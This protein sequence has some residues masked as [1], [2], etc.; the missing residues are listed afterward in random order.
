MAARQCGLTRTEPIRHFLPVSLMTLSP[1]IANRKVLL[2]DPDSFSRRLVTDTLGV[3]RLQIIE[4]T[5]FEPDPAMWEEQQ[6]GLVVINGTAHQSDVARMVHELRADRRTA[7]TPILLLTSRSEDADG[8]HD[9][10]IDHAIAEADRCV[11]KPFSPLELI[12]AVDQL[13]SSRRPVPAA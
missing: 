7:S 5:E 13:L 10:A 1:N 8:S 3:K 12:E 11:L 2:V 9:G 6:P 4:A